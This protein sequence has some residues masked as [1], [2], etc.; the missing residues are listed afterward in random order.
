M[1]T[2]NHDEHY[3][4]AVSTNV[5]GFEETKAYATPQALLKAFK[6]DGLDVIDIIRLRQGEPV[7]LNC[8]TRM[9]IVDITY[10]RYTL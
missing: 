7:M 8:P 1:T 2:L 4:S 5:Y 3:F 10:E 6:S 9:E